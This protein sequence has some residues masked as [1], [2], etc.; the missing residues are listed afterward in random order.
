MHYCCFIPT[1]LVALGIFALWSIYGEQSMLTKLPSIICRTFYPALDASTWL[2]YSPKVSWYARNIMLSINI[3]LLIAIFTA[4][5]SANY[6]EELA[7]VDL[8]FFSNALPPV[9]PPHELLHREYEAA[10]QVS[11]AFRERDVTF[12]WYSHAGTRDHLYRWIFGNATNHYNISMS[13]CLK[14][15]SVAGVYQFMNGSSANDATVGDIY[16]DLGYGNPLDFSGNRTAQLII[17]AEAAY[18]DIS[19]FLLNSILCSGDPQIRDDLRRQLLFRSDGF[20]SDGRIT[21]VILQSVSGMVIYF[22]WNS[23]GLLFNNHPGIKLLL[24]GIATL[25]L[26][27]VVGL[28]E[29]LRQEGLIQPYEAAFVGSVYVA[30]ARSLILQATRSGR[31]SGQAA[32]ACLPATQMMQAGVQAGSGSAAVQELGIAASADVPE[33]QAACTGPD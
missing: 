22:A 19:T 15:S 17:N 21:T 14:R 1:S 24:G 13:T 20:R 18:Q 12:K 4:L 5:S 26:V 32:G 3:Y 9:Q 11:P 6:G 2:P 29:I 31:T 27:L 25:Q 28:L 16:T 33:I 8:P 30:K 10:E 7:V 23:I